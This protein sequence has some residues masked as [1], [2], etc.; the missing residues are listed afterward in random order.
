MMTPEPTRL[1]PG[2]LRIAAT[3]ALKWA[4]GVGLFAALVLLAVPN[5]YIS[6]VRLLPVEGRSL[7]VGLGGLANT[8]AALGLSLPGT[9][10]SDANYVD[11]L[12]SRRIREQLLATEFEFEESRLYFGRPRRKRQTL[13]GYLGAKNMDQALRKLSAIVR[14]RRDLKTRVVTIEAETRSPG[15][16]MLVVQRTSQLLEA[17]LQQKGQTRGGAKAAFSEARLQDARRNLD[18]SEA[19][20]LQFLVNNRN[21][22]V[23]SDPDIRLRGSRMEADYKLAE[24]LVVTLAV[25]HEQALM[26]EKNDLPILNVLDP[27]SLPTEKSR[28][29][30]GQ[31]V[32]GAVLIAFV[33]QMAWRMRRLIRQYVLPAGE[34]GDEA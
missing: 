22:M 25:S 23:S 10:G 2:E 12:N 18:A 16:S 14:A 33:A 29:A 13:Y 24:Q 31:L 17:F 19:R 1:H 4:I 26:E 20:F 5:H 8:A 6:V 32:L 3:L 7:G 9:E 30:R 27:G 15:L 28:P 11:I 34:T 21:Y